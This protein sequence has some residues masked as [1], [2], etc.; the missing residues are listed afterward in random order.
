MD[1]ISAANRIRRD[2]SRLLGALGDGD[3]EGGARDV[4]LTPLDHQGVVASL[5]QLVGHTVFQVALMFDQNLITG[6]FWAVD[7]HQEHVVTW[8]KKRGWQH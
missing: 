7:A 2:D 8:G 3:M 4:I 5:F 6:E 1:I